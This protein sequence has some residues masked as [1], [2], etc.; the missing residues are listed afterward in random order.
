MTG[1]RFFHEEG[2]IL[3]KK[4]LREKD[5]LVILLS[6]H[7]G[8]M[9]LM[10]FGSRDPKSRK[11]GALEL[12]NS[13]VF[14]VREGSDNR[15]SLDQVKLLKSRGFS[16]VDSSHQDLEHYYR[17]M[18]ILKLTDAML[19]ESQSVQSVYYNLNVALD[20]VREDAIV[21]VYWIRLLNDLG[22][23]P[24]WKL[25]CSCHVVLAEADEML[26][27]TENKGFAHRHCCQ[28]GGNILLKQVD[29]TLVK[30]MRYCQS[31]GMD[32]ALRVTV[33]R[34]VLADIKGI[35]ESLEIH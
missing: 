5:E 30:V 2:I 23:L 27:S 19:E 35:L 6:L 8:K 15:N 11:A 9:V 13:V 22:Y 33:D 34:T 20:N 10:C 28:V 14:Q 7:H 25:C 16:Y 26:F 21:V 24:D 12:A 29:I 4:P 3:R 17:A 1:M 32:D 18:E 31:V